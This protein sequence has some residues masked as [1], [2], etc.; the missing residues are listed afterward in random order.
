M[1][2]ELPERRPSRTRKAKVSGFTVFLRIGEYDDGTP[3][4][5]FIDISKDGTILRALFNTLAKTASLA[6]QYGTP[7]RVV[8]GA[9]AGVKVEPCGRVQGSENVPDADSIL[10][11][12]GRQI[13]AD[14][15]D[16]TPLEGNKDSL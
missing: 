5:L 12:I 10:D 9:M 13:W 14:Y 16:G 1:R 6:L 2:R 4:E 3:G 7:L 15:G 8:V 11:Y